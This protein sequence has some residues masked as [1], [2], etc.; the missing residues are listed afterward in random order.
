MLRLGIA[1]AWLGAVLGCAA[2]QPVLA[3]NEQLRRVGRAAA[4]Q[5]IDAC[6]ALAREYGVKKRG[7]GEENIAR[8]G[9]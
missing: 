3:P 6:L 8:G 5:D 1:L 9:D 7:S 4:Q 2:A